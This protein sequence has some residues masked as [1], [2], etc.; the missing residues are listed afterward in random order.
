MLALGAAPLVAVACGGAH[1]TYDGDAFGAC[2]R[3]L[4]GAE[5]FLA[6]DTLRGATEPDAAVLLGSRLPGAMAA[7]LDSGEYLLFFAGRDEKAAADGARWMKVLTEKYP[8][9]R[10]S[11][12]SVYGNLVVVTRP[13]PSAR[14]TRLVSDCRDEAAKA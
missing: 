13:H 11:E 14:L 4:G 2:L 9:A 12:T 8:E 3:R 6:R 7:S 1:T 5:T 10:G